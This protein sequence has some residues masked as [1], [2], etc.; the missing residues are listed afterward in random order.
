MESL[1]VLKM[2]GKQFHNGYNL[3]YLPLS[4]AIL[5]YLML[6]YAILLHLTLIQTGTTFRCFTNFF[7]RYFTYTT[8]SKLLFA[9]V[10]CKG[11]LVQSVESSFLCSFA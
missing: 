10:C 2:S 9:Q 5:R 4:Y 11:F 8:L 1:I 6:F 3:G 7:L